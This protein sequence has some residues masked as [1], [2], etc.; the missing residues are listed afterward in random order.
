MSYIA[1]RPFCPRAVVPRAEASARSAATA[2]FWRRL[3]DAIMAARQRQAERHIARLLENS[4]GLLTDDIERE[5]MRRDAERHRR[6][7][8]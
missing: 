7:G 5:I 6:F 2:G 1:P 3:Y 8:D 4:G